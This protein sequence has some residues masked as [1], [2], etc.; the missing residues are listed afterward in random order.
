MTQSNSPG[1]SSQRWLCRTMPPQSW[2]QEARAVARTVSAAGFHRWGR[3]WRPEA[4]SEE[5]AGGKGLWKPQPGRMAGG[6]GVAWSHPTEDCRGVCPFTHSFICSINFAEPS[7]HATLCAARW[8][9]EMNPPSPGPGESSS[10]REMELGQT[11]A[12]LLPPVPYCCEWAGSPDQDGWLTGYRDW[13]GGTVTP[14][15]WA[16]RWTVIAPQKWG[17]WEHPEEHG[18]PREGLCGTCGVWGAGQASQGLP[19]GPDRWVRWSQRL[20]AGTEP[21]RLPG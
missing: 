9:T 6:G 7:S 13:A 17:T 16:A 5:G 18:E 15:D 4:D 1:T 14:C 19:G 12:S 2:S 8:G 21:W 11:R 20:Q 3:K 10:K